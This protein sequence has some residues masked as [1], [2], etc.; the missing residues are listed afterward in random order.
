MKSL[1]L[2]PLL[3]LFP[4]QASARDGAFD[5]GF[6]AGGTFVDPL[7]VLGTS[8]SFSPRVGYWINDTLLL[9]A[10]LGFSMGKTSV[11]TPDPFN[12][13][14]LTPRVNLVGRVWPDEPISLLF[15]AGLGTWYKSINDDGAL[16]LPQ[17]DGSDLDFLGNA[18]PG[19]LIPI[20]DT[21]AFRSDLRWMMSLG[22]ENWENHGDAFMSWELTG[23]I[24][25]IIGG[26]KDT[27]KD[28]IADEDDQCIDEAE[29]MDQFQDE[30]GC[31]EADNDEDG[32]VD[33]DDATC[34]NDAEDLDGFE[35]QD[36]CPDPDNDNDGILDA[37]DACPMN[38]GHESAKGCPDKDGDSL[39]DGKDEC[40]NEAGP[41]ASFGCPD[42]DGDRV[43]DYRDTCPEEAAQADIDPL[44][45]NGCPAVVYYAEDQLVIEEQVNFASGRATIQQSSNR[46][47]DNVA[48]AL[49]LAPD[50]TKV[51]VGGHTD[52]SGDDAKNL[53][54]SQDR[55]QAVVDRL[56]KHG[57]E[58]ERLIAKGYGE[59]KPIGDNETKEGKEANRRVE[60]IILE[61]DKNRRF[62]KVEEKTAPR[63]EDAEGTDEEPKK[64]APRGPAKEE[65][66]EAPTE[67]KKTAPRA[68]AKE[69]A[70]E[71]P[72]EK[73]EEK[74]TAPRAPAK[75]EAAPPP[76][77]KAEEP[78]AE[79]AKAEEPKTVSPGKALKEA[80]E[81]AAEGADK[82]E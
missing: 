68:P 2:L 29:D 42:G 16:A 80:G 78:K 38:T 33:A 3:L 49:K 4:S 27:D 62:R 19:I 37:D 70:A 8:P 71:A 14:S 41:E 13:L 81:K 23:G 45:N 66:T 11:G 54:L 5:L 36:G 76:A 34:P 18:G 56:V 43:P 61:Q 15:V 44:R 75:E 47:L 73:A 20:G 1:V 63:G 17:G 59:T 28:G 26:T 74:K 72:A 51:E 55:A 69:E 31:P 64:T 77:E 21:L 65:A 60:F 52:S 6:A 46:L 50:V 35:D 9:E 79:E 24:A 22:N 7:E 10:D 57:V 12:F 25:L 39:V 82:A 58:A 30:D 53:K 48:T 40:P 67:E 32:I